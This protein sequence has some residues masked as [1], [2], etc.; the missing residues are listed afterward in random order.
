MKRK[1]KR[2]KNQRRNQDHR[3]MIPELRNPEDSV[4]IAVRNVRRRYDDI[5]PTDYLKWR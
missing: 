2:E 3:P 1:Q 5:N 4:D